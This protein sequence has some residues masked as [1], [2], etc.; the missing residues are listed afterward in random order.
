[1]NRAH[2]D[3][4]LFVPASG[5]TGS[6]EYYRAVNLAAALRRLRSDLETHV[7]VN[8][9]ASIRTD[10]DLVV[11]RLSDTPAR[12]GREVE[13]CLDALQPGLAVFDGSGRVRQMR[14]VRRRGGRVAWIS[15]RP[16]RRRRAFS[17]RR[18]RHID[19]HVVLDTA[20]PAPQL[21]RFES[22]LAHAW[23]RTHHRFASAVAPVPADLPAALQ[24]LAADGPA[25]FV[26]GGG[27]HVVDGRPV[28]EL[29]VEAAIRFHRET[30]VPTCA[31]LGPQY[32]GALQ[33]TDGIHVVPEL[34]TEQ[35]S[36]LVESACLLVTGAG[37]LLS[38]QVILARRPAVMVAT[39][40]HDQPAR[41]ARYAAL[42]AVRPARLDVHSMAEAAIDLVR[43][44]G[45]IEALIEGQSRLGVRD[46]TDRIAAWLIGLLER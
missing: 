43:R 18:L 2:T 20:D 8:D 28:P 27:G 4:V 9:R 38:N 5:P 36:R 42:G 17:P 12:A 24:G 21:G 29:F 39:G 3:R 32:R 44:D 25:V 7:V 13:R 23:P 22:I 34:S 40:G 31:V 45:V 35:L 26:S 1:M 19:L 14:T 11:H 37:T 41:L 33:A 30:G 6:G 16:G 10:E 15:D 46:D